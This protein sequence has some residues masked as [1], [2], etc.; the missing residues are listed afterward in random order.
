MSATALR[1]LTAAGAFELAA[2]AIEMALAANVAT[3]APD[4]TTA[5]LYQVASRLFFVSLL[6]LG[7]AVGTVAVRAIAP[8]WRR[9]PGGITS[10]TLVLASLAVAHPHGVLGG[11]VLPAE[12]FLVVWVTAGAVTDLARREPVS[13][14][15]P[16]PARVQPDPSR[17]P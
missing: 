6:W 12:L 2:T 13:R 17:T 10:A 7:L 11:A 9:W 1:L 16:V 8:A 4:S 14:P 3:N 15:E 5:A